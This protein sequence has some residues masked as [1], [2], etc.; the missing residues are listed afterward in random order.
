[1]MVFNLHLHD[2]QDLKESKDEGMTGSTRAKRQRQAK[3]SGPIRNVSSK[4]SAKL[5]TERR[6]E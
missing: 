4:P 1:M 2:Q 6:A 3:L 5:G